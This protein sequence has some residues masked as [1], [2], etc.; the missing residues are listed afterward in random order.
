MKRTG[1]PIAICS[2]L[3]LLSACSGS[4]ANGDTAGT[5]NTEA[6]N[7]DGNAEKQG[8]D[9]TV[10]QG[11]SGAAAAHT[12]D[13]E[14]T[15][16]VKLV[17]AS[18]E[19]SERLKE[20]KR[21]YEAAHPNVTIELQ[22]AQ[23]EFKD[24]DSQMA[25]I[26]KFVT[27]TNTAM[28]AG[29]GPDLLELELLPT[30]KYVGRQLLAD[31]SEL[32]AQDAS[33]RKEDY[34]T[35]I[36]DNLQ[37]GGKLYGMPLSFFLVGLV[38]D[39][40]AIGKDGGQVDDGSWTWDEFAET[41][42]R[43][44]QKGTYPHA[45]AGSPDYMLSELVSENY[46]QFVDEAGRKANFDS[47]DFVVLMKQVKD[48]FDEGVAV[49][50]AKGGARSK[51]DTY[52]RE[53]SFPSPMEYLLAMNSYE[54][55]GKLYTKPHAKE[56]GAGGYFSANETIG[57]NAASPV[58]RQAWD[59]VKFL[60]NEE[61]EAPPDITLGNSGFSI[62]KIAFDKQMKTLREKGEVPAYKNGP[63][64]ADAFKV[65]ESLLAPLDALVAG[66]VHAVGKSS[67]I[68]DFITEESKAYFAGQK[69]AEAA[70]KLIQSKA[71]LY[72]NE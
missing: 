69:S 68:N 11:G 40:A 32:M 22:A 48:L 26:E 51:V 39:E 46:A 16:P 24:L 20:A 38:G 17:F 65:D 5:P 70:T 14:P 7:K 28:L 15:G 4:H 29:S 18:F 23:T 54:G 3:L 60:L 1:I 36:L 59:F 63:A 33:F 27:T 52:F 21:K 47:P 35:N 13:G 61:G 12:E 10:G 58:K 25:N 44:M 64:E 66:A 71:S 42:K 43:L 2:L 55:H 6:A 37:V 49:D 53:T 9:R 34:F 72:L 8:N 62:S 57:I 41:A 30:E 50:I 56:L 45:L 67:K 19:P 31:Y